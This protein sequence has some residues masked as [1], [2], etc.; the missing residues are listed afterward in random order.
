M[1]RFFNSSTAWSW[2]TI[3]CLRASGVEVHPGM[4]YAGIVSDGWQPRWR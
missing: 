2:W 1:N 4:L 3:A